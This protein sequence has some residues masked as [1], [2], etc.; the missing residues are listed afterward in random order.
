MVGAVLGVGQ[1][2]IGLAPGQGVGVDQHLFLGGR[3]AEP[4]GVDRV[5]RARLVADIVFERA[6][7]RGHGGIVGLDAALHL[8]EQLVLQRF[9]PGQHRLGVGVLRL[10]MGAD[11]LAQGLGIVQHLAPVLVLHP[12]VVVGADAA[13]L[14]DPLGAPR[15]YGRR[16]DGCAHAAVL[17]W[18]EDRFN[19]RLGGPPIAAKTSPPLWDQWPR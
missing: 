11:V 4:A 3:G 18:T 5:L 13:Q 7:G 17:S 12:G 1:A 15:G 16:R 19:S 9:G 6:V 10:Q 2:E 8:L 14:L